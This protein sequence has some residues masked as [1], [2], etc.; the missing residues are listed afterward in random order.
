MSEM[1]LVEV[2]GSSEVRTPTLEPGQGL[3]V[4]HCLVSELAIWRLSR[5]VWL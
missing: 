3:C 1:L 4:R 5:I 2:A